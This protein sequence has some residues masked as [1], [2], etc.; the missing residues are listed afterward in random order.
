MISIKDNCM[1]VMFVLLATQRKSVLW[2][3]MDNIQIKSRILPKQIL[4]KRFA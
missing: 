1:S 3:P 2:F 4:S